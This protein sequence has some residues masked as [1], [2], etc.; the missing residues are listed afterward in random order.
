MPLDFFFFFFFF[1]LKK[2]VSYLGVE[3]EKGANLDRGFEQDVVHVLD[4]GPL[5]SVDVRVGPGQLERLPHEEAAEDLVEPIPILRLADDQVLQLCVFHPD[6]VFR[7]HS[8]FETQSF[9]IHLFKDNNRSLN[10]VSDPFLEQN[11]GS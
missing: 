7:L 2:N 3:V 10:P 8:C 1:F 6:T 4:V 9:M 5:P 11:I